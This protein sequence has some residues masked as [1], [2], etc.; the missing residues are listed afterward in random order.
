[1][2]KAA[3]VMSIVALSISALNLALS[4]LT[5]LEKKHYIDV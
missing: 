1:M 4:I 5:M 2:K 3:L